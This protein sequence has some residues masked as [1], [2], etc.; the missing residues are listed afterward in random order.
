MKKIPL[1]LIL[2]LFTALPSAHALGVRRSDTDRFAGGVGRLLM[3]PFHLIS[4]TVRGTLHGPL[5]LGT[6][7]GVVS[8]AAYTVTDVAGGAFDI[9]AAS[10]P[11][12]KYA[13]LAL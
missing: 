13:V 5:G 4:Q 12:A 7:A 8:G 6:V 11:Y 1:L 9:A 3:A 10:A 2:I